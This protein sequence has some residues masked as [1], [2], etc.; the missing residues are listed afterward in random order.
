MA[1][2]RDYFF[3]GGLH[4]MS[5][6]MYELP[7]FETL[8]ELLSLDSH[9]SLTSSSHSLRFRA[10]YSPQSLRSSSTL[11]A[12]AFEVIRSCV[13]WKGWVLTVFPCNGSK[14]DRV[15]FVESAPTIK[16]KWPTPPKTPQSAPPSFPETTTGPF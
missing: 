10:S 14:Y 2:S 3:H 8:M 12:H 9:F 5:F 11:I 15:L 1:P 16:T 4:N 6:V 7:S 13:C